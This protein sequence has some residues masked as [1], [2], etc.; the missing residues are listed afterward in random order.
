M[1]P[2]RS[3][4]TDLN[5]K[6]NELQG[7]NGIFEFEL[8]V[9]NPPDRTAVSPVYHVVFSSTQCLPRGLLPFSGY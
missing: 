9:S 6:A 7:R 8:K 4:G 2:I 3:L 5:Q 1:T